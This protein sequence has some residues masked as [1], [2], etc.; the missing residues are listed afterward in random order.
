[1]LEGLVEESSVEKPL[2]PMT[3]VGLP[4][5]RWVWRR[6]TRK[7]SYTVAYLLGMWGVEREPGEGPTGW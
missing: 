1:M 4:R 2:L 3:L 7:D 6:E 5:Q